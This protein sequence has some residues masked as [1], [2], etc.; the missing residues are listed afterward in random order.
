MSGSSTVRRLG[1]P[2]TCNEIVMGCMSLIR[3][4]NR[5]DSTH[6]RSVRKHGN[7]RRFWCGSWSHHPGQSSKPKPG[8]GDEVESAADLFVKVA[9]VQAIGNGAGKS[10]H[11]PRNQRAG[12]RSFLSRYFECFAGPEKLSLLGV[13]HHDPEKLAVLTARYLWRY[14]KPD[15]H[16]NTPSRA[17]GLGRDLHFAVCTS[18]TRM[19]C[20][21]L[22]RCL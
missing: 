15:R 22:K 1:W 10:R 3:F 14:P 21:W 6:V 2:L 9:G 17:S 16:R 5:N 8:S 18:T 20:T 11:S 19:R 12:G 7:N 4:K 13:R